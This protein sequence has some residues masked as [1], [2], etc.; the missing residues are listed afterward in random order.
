MYTNYIKKI[1]HATNGDP[2]NARNVLFYQSI[3]KIRFEAISQK[4]L[5]FTVMRQIIQL[6][7]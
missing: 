2:I 7:N 4:I 1:K 6:I 3:L 5:G